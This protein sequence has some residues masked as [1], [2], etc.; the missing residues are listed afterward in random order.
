M[1]GI[2]YGKYLKDDKEFLIKISDV[3][4]TDNLYTNYNK[5]EYKEVVVISQNDVSLRKGPSVNYYSE[6]TKIPKGT[7]MR[8]Y[9]AKEYENTIKWLYVEYDGK[10][11]W[12]DCEKSKVG[13]KYKEDRNI[14]IIEEITIY[15]NP[16]MTTPVDTIK[17]HSIVNTKDMVSIDFSNFFKSP[18][19]KKGFNIDDDEIMKSNYIKIDGKEGYITIENHG[20]EKSGTYTVDSEGITLYKEPDDNSKILIKSL[21]VG[22]VLDYTYYSEMK[23]PGGTT[24]SYGFWAYTEYKGRKGWVQAVEQELLDSQKE[25]IESINSKAEKNSNSGVKIAIIIVL[26]IALLA[27]VV[28]LIYR[29]K[30]KK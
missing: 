19:V 17:A 29:L 21:P 4:S 2:L 14:M 13:Y 26:S 3:K 16:E 28:V 7:L 25:A 15:S 8:G 1:N 30:N 10:S 27:A 20:I 22:T 6:I 18:D 23:H 24:F 5:D 11:G 9:A 12:I